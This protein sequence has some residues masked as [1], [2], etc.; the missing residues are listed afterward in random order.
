MTLLYAVV[1]LIVDVINNTV[2]TWF[3]KKRNYRF[4]KDYYDSLHLQQFVFGFIN[5]YL[6]LGYVAF[7]RQSFL[8]LF[9]LMFVTLLFDWFK[10]MVIRIVPQLLAIF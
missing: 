7:V 9:T 6:P 1:I 8:A 2:V 4:K 5:V 3:I 10:S